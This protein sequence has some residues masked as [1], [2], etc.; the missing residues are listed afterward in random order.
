MKYVNERRYVREESESA[1]WQR[2]RRFARKDI[3]GGGGG[4]RQHQRLSALKT[5]E[6]LLN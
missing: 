2:W 4:Q 6:S 3:R 5:G 1:S